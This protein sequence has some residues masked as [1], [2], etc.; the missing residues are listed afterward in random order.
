MINCDHLYILYYIVLY[1]YT[2][3]AGS[4]IKELSSFFFQF[5]SNLFYWSIL[6]L[7]SLIFLVE[8]IYCLAGD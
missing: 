3:I 5:M 4:M 7:Q 6:D 1:I 2:K 8:N